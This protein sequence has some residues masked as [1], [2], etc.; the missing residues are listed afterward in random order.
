MLVGAQRMGL[1]SESGRA[2]CVPCDST[3]GGDWRMQLGS[4]PNHPAP[5]AWDGLVTEDDWQFLA[6]TS[7]LGGLK[8]CLACCASV[9]Q[10]H[11]PR[12]SLRSVARLASG[13]AQ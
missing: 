7:A 11:A 5:W 4:E 10:Q 8:I 6:A 9:C 3:L 1:K 13:T 2:D 12:L